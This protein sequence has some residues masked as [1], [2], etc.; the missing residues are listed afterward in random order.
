MQIAKEKQDL[1]SHV[2]ELAASVE[3]LKR[4]KVSLEQE[5]EMEEENLTNRM[6]R[7]VDALLST[8]RQVDL[9]LQARGMSL[10][11]LGVVVPSAE[12]PQGNLSMPRR[13]SGS[14]P[15]I[16]GMCSLG[17]TSHGSSYAG[18]SPRHLSGSSP[19]R[20]SGGV[21]S[22]T[23]KTN[24]NNHSAVQQRASGSGSEPVG[25]AAH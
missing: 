14:V 13:S 5:M 6:Q 20:S 24:N 8:L 7:Q 10:S 21:G 3:K 11:E 22:L 2:L 19:V 17:R 4:D 16:A 25:G 18:T 12:I 1:H 15:I 9:K 23:L